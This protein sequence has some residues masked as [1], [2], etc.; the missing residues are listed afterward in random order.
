MDNI[1]VIFDMD[2]TLVD[3]RKDITISINYVRNTKGLPPLDEQQVIKIINFK[4]EKLALH[5]YHTEEY[6]PE[7]REIFENHYLTQ[8]TKNVKPYEG[9]IELLSS[10]KKNNVKLSVATNAPTKFG[11]RILSAAKIDHYFDHIV[12]SCKVKN[13]K[14]DPDMI[15]LIQ[16][17]YSDKNLN[18]NF[19]VGD[20][21][22]DIN[23]AKNANI[24][25]IFV[26]W[27]YGSFDGI[28]PDFTAEKPEEIVKYILDE[29]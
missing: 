19:L 17:F 9:V 1:L 10:L 13:A 15:Y 20:N 3:T 11:E 21:H 4:R 24:P 27:G 22:T 18:K 23:A 26:K 5:L 6:L 29:N 7:D 25:S 8:C 14:P 28:T 16:D 12:G 2:G